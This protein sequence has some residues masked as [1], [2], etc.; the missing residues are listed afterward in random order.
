ME[1]LPTIGERL[2]ARGTVRGGWGPTVIFNELQSKQ[3]KLAAV[4]A[5]VAGAVAVAQ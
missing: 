3:K 2:G 1:P 4:V 5:V